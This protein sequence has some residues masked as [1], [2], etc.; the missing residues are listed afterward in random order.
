MCVSAILRDH[1][2]LSKS[3]ISLGAAQFNVSRKA[4]TGGMAT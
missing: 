3:F 4:G 2:L 1:L